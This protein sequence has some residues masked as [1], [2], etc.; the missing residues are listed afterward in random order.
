MEGEAEMSEDWILIILMGAGGA[1]MI[2]GMWLLEQLGLFI[3]VG[4]CCFQLRIRDE[5][6]G[7]VIFGCTLIAYL[8][9]RLVK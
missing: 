8:Y 7:L 2:T 3:E 5:K 6:S 4:E 9:S 1:D